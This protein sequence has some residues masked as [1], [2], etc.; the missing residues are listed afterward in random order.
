M[1][2]EQVFFSLGGVA[3]LSEESHIVHV[4]NPSVIRQSS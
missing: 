4:V 3:E 1:G 2:D